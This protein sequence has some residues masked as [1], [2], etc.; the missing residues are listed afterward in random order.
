MR[1]T[2]NG[3]ALDP[4][5][6]GDA[7]AAMPVAP[8]PPPPRQPPKPVELTEQAAPK[9]AAKKTTGVT[10]RKKSISGNLEVAQSTPDPEAESAIPVARVALVP[11]VETELTSV[12]SSASPAV[13]MMDPHVE[14]SATLVADHMAQTSAQTAVLVEQYLPDPVVNPE[15]QQLTCWL[16]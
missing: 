4:A 8:A 16:A 12:L 1:Q 13:P 9:T 5:L 3:T 7:A 10:R 2:M 11:R 15:R 6:D 14:L